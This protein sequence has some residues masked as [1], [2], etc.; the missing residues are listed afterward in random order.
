M[1]MLCFCE[2]APTYLHN[3]LIPILIQDKA[4]KRYLLMS[5]D[6]RQKM[7]KNLRKTNYPVFEKTCKELGI[8]YTFPP[9]Y[10]RKIHRRLATKK[11]LCIQV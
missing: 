9:P 6:Q 8:E 3:T 11:A 5:L 7:L 1:T 4:H 2:V 10:H